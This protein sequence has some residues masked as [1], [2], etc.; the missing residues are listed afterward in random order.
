MTD[1]DLRMCLSAVRATMSAKP[2]VVMRGRNVSLSW[3]ATVPSSCPPLDWSIEPGSIS[4]RS[5]G[6]QVVRASDEVWV[7]YAW[8]RGTSFS[9][10]AA[11]VQLSIYDRERP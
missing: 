4:V 1:D 6:E 3:H 8:I 7:L 5:S 9:M 2:D 10:E 11:R